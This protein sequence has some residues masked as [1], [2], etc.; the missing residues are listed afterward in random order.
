MVGKTMFHHIIR[1]VLHRMEGGSSHGI[2]ITLQHPAPSKFLWEDYWNSVNYWQE[3]TSPLSGS[4]QQ[5]Q[6]YIGNKSMKN[7]HVTLI[8]YITSCGLGLLS[9]G[10]RQGVPLPILGPRQQE[11]C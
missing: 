6:M 4:T 7:Q 3:G 2:T 1:P 5:D 9:A 10:T 11:L 8:Y